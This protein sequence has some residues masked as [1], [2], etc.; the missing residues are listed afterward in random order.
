[1]N[2]LPHA[3]GVTLHRGWA[4]ATEEDPAVRPRGVACKAHEE[5]RNLPRIDNKSNSTKGCKY[6][7]SL[8][9]R[10]VFGALLKYGLGVGVGDVGIDPS[11]RDGRALCYP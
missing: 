4:E 11:H 9:S 1:M 6:K 2:P 10:L 3:Q 7:N 5:E 8:F